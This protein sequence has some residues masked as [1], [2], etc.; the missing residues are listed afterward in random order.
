M[1]FPI[2]KDVLIAA[3]IGTIMIHSESAI[4]SAFG[5]AATFGAY[6]VVITSGTYAWTRLSIWITSKKI[7]LSMSYD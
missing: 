5:V 1:V 2:K 6:P 3:I 7:E 4:Q